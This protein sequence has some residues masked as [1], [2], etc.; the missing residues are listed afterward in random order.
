MSFDCDDLGCTEKGR[1][2]LCGIVETL[3]RC[4]NCLEG[5]FGPKGEDAFQGGEIGAWYLIRDDE[6]RVLLGMLYRIR[7]KESRASD[8]AELIVF[9]S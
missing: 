7:M 8:L 1:R 3:P 2:T 5:A 6:A 9:S 4:S